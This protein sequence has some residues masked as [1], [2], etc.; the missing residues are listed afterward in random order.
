MYRNKFF[1]GA[2]LTLR[3]VFQALT[4]V[5]E[6]NRAGEIDIPLTN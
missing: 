1:E 5:F 3:K 6:A 2:N 4:A